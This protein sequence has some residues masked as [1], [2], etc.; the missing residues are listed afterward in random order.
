MSADSLHLAVALDGTGFHPASWRHAGARPA[1]LF[2]PGYWI[3]QALTA[4]RGLL[5]LV[6]IDDSFG[7]QSSN[8]RVL[9]GRTD[10]VRGR[11]DAVMLASLIAP[12]T[13]HLGLVPTANTT[14]TEPFHLASTFSTLDWVSQGRA[15]WRPQVSGSQHDA[16]HVGRR[17]F[18]RADPTRRDDPAATAFM[19]D[20]FDE[21]TDAVDV[22]R[23]L[24][25]SWEDDAVI[26]DVATGRF[27]D[28]AKLHHVDFEGRFFSVKGPSIVPRPPQGNPL[29]VALAHSQI[30]FEFA[31]RAADVV[32]VTPADTADVPRWVADVRL[33]EAAVGR[34]R[35]AVADHGRPRGVPRRDQCRRDRP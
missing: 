14:H 19:R 28:R 30:P 16:D 26:R 22:V 20:L 4:E 33:A 13:T 32:L 18:P 23:R 24:W 11:L 21:A 12:R 10:Q 7:L 17:Q 8:R 3:D 1:E 5:D 25:D 9:D 34:R 2:T 27:V 29:V 15:G 6:T 31:A 35:R